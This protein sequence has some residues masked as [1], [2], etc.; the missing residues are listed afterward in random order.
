MQIFLTGATGFL[1]TV[2]LRELLSAGH[3]VTALSRANKILSAADRLKY[4][5]ADYDPAFQWN[6]YFGTTLSVVEGDTS[7]AFFG[8]QE[9]D[10]FAHASSVDMLLHNAACTALE[11]DW[12]IYQEVNI[13][14]TLKAIEFASKTRRKEMAHVS[15]AYVAGERSGLIHETEADLNGGFRNNYEKSKAV[16]EQ[17]VRRAANAGRIRSMFLRPSIIVGDSRSGWMCPNHHFFDFI[18][19][20]L[21]I[22]GL[23]RNRINSTSSPEDSRFR[24]PGDPSATKNFVPVDHVAKLISILITKD[25]AWGKT[26]H[27]TNPDPVKLKSL[28]LYVQTALDWPELKWCLSGEMQDLSPLERRFSRSVK[29]YEKYFWQ[30]PVFDQTE[31]KTLLGDGL[32]IPERMSQTVINRMVAFV[33]AKYEALEESRKSGAIQNISRSA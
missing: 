30:E 31:L 12:K 14:G 8:L 7:R 17:E 2:L 18:S 22:R 27:L 1:G 4:A 15:S 19:R 26:F 5:L 11:A 33:Q 10:F 24:V 9:K 23:I 6:R 25:V 13:G 29:L 16:S 3:T 28:E 21:F 32:I 20:L